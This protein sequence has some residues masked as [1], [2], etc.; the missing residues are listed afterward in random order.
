MNNRTAR[1]ARLSRFAFLSSLAGVLLLAACT[2]RADMRPL[3]EAGMDSPSVA[4]LRKLDPT[5]AE[6]AELVKVKNAGFA[7]S[8]CIDLVRAARSHNHAF[9]AGDDVATLQRIGLADATILE[10]ARLD[11]FGPWTDEVRA[12]RLAGVTDATIL[13]L[14]ERHAAGKP[15][16][17]SFALARLKNAG[18]NDLMLLELARRGLTDSDANEILRLPPAQ[19]STTELFRRYPPK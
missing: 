2:K 19:R 13:A 17:S 9:T 14:A 10:L 4:E 5:D 6:V 16:L 8:F 7:D 3:G 1:R 15:V 11:Q 12:M 18:F